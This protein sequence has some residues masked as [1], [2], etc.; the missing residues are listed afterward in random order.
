MGALKLPWLWAALLDHVLGDLAR[1]QLIHQQ[2][3]PRAA[4]LGSAKEIL[5][6][7]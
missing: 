4:L 7:T 2:N 5:N 1:D 3:D 6:S